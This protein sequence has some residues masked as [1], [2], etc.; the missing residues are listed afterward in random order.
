MRQTHTEPDGPPKKPRPHALAL[1][2]L[3]ACIVGPV[4]GDSTSTTAD[5][6]TTTDIPT[7]T[8]PPPTTSST[9]S[10]ISTTSTTSTG[11]FVI[12]PDLPP[13][14][15]KCNGLE[16]LDPECA[17]GQKCTLDGEFGASHCVD[18]VDDPKGLHEPCTTQGDVLSGIDDCDLGL[19]CWSL[20]TEGHGICIGLADGNPGNPTCADS[21]AHL[22]LCSE[23]T[24]GVCLP[25][26][27]PL[28]QDCAAAGIC[29]YF[30]DAFVCYL[31][32]SG[33]E[34]QANDACE[35]SNGCDE[36]L[37][38][39]DSV[40]ASIACMQNALGCCQPYCGFSKNAPCPNPD[41]KCL[42]YFDPMNE[43]PEGL[44]DVGICAI[45]P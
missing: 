45:P 16:Q 27:D 34:G 22:D 29:I 17:P 20:D 24:F 37:Y 33:D 11:D 6:L 14:P 40:K 10:T 18:I 8:E 2:A 31:D 32:A 39:L 3:S 15:V 5:P 42:Q 23:C 9:T 36:G 25:T 4:P 19:L 38:C 41:Q 30:D 28:L 44:E 21:S 35:S 12:E 7:T 43:I 26:C 1:L 13:N